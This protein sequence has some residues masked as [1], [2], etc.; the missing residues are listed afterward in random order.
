MW[1]GEI[2]YIYIIIYVCIYIYIHMWVGEKLFH[3]SL[4]RLARVIIFIYI[5]I[6]FGGGRLIG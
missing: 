4:G 5:Y 6:I 3:Q 1:V 2:I